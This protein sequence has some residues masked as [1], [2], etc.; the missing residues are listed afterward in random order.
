MDLRI[1]AKFCEIGKAEMTKRVHGIHHEKGWYFPPP[2]WGFWND[3]AKNFTGSPF[4]RSSPFCQAFSNSFS[5]LADNPQ[6]SSRLITI[7]A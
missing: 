4:S 7:S 6:M 1:P 5:Y 2:L 3:L